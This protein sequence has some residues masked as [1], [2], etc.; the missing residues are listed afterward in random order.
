VIEV[1]GVPIGVTI[2]EDIWAP[3][4]ARAAVDAGAQLLVNLNASPFHT[5]KSNERESVI[6]ERV[7][8]TGCPV[9]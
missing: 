6:A 3:E 4:P 2:C 9:V 5:G 7:G 1:A 8:E